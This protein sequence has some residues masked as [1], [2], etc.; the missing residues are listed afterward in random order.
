MTKKKTYKVWALWS[1]IALVGILAVGTIATLAFTNESATPPTTVMENVETVNITNPPA[2]SEMVLGAASPDFMTNYISVGGVR[3]WWYSTPLTTAST[4]L[5]SIQAPA[6][7]STLMFGSL[8]IRTGTTSALYL[9][10]GK[11][12]ANKRTAT[13]TNLGYVTVLAANAVGTFLAS[14]TQSG[15][16]PANVFA[17]N[18]WFVVNASVPGYS[19]WTA[20]ALTGRCKA[21]FIENVEP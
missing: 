18:T 6:A 20:A 3:Q 4:T 21:F 10:F 13:T 19:D 5:C 12:A 17:P 7:T 1:V 2:Q 11:G 16:D 14:T 9:E 8:N 15:A